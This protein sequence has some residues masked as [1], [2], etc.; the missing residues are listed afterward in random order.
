MKEFQRFLLAIQNYTRIPVSKWIKYDK[1]NELKSLM[2]LPLVGIIVGA[3]SGG[4]YLLSAMAFPVTI[5][6]IFSM[7]AS[8][9]ITGA[10]HEDGLADTCDGFGGGWSKNKILE[11][12]KDSRI[13][14]FGV[15]GL[16]LVLLLKFLT[17]NELIL[18]FTKNMQEFRA[19]TMISEL[20]PFEKLDALYLNI[21]M[22]FIMISGHSLSRFIALTGTIGYSYVRKED[23]QSKMTVLT[24]PRLSNVRMIIAGIFGVFPLILSLNPYILLILPVLFII[25]WLMSQY[26][27]KWIGGYTGDCLGAIQQVTEVVFY[28]FIIVN[29]QF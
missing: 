3:I 24:Q 9:L 14:T 26:F 19:E 21:I 10:F 5:A 8:V 17:L 2:Y 22:I 4:V 20:N 16:I 7:L 18:D 12:M 15:V 11:I 29:V 23:Q 27:K 28:L 13:G 6:I 25:R 1:E